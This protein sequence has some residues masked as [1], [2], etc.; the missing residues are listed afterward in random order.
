[1]TCEENYDSFYGETEYDE[2]NNPTKI[3]SYG[4]GWDKF[5]DYPPE[6]YG[7]VVEIDPK[8]GIAKKHIALGRFG[9][10]NVVP[11]FN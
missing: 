5:Y 4:Y 7:W 2:N 10:T 1:M 3:P 9:I 11:Y 8:E 6:H